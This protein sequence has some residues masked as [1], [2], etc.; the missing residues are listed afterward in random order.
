MKRLLPVLL[1]V[2][3]VGL[4]AEALAQ[5]AAPT[6]DVAPGSTV[7]LRSRA[8]WEGIGREFGD[9]P[10]SPEKAK[11]IAN[12][13]ANQLLADG[14]PP[15]FSL[16]RR[17]VSAFRSGR[18]STA[19][20]GDLGEILTSAFKGAGFRA[21][22]VDILVA[23]SGGGHLPDRRLNPLDVNTNH[24]AVVVVMEGV[25]YAFDL[26]MHAGN[27]G[28]SG[29]ELSPY[30]GM[31]VEAW[32][33]LMDDM[34][35]GRFESDACSTSGPG[36]QVVVLEAMVDRARLITFLVTDGSRPVPNATVTFDSV[37]RPGRRKFPPVVTDAA[38][39]AGSRELSHK[40][41]TTDM[42]RV[43]VKAPG[44]KDFAQNLAINPIRQWTY[45][46]VLTREEPKPK[47]PPP[48]PLPPP[49]PPGKEPQ[50]YQPFI[51]SQSQMLGPL[52]TLFSAGLPS[53]FDGTAGGDA[54]PRKPAPG[55]TLLGFKYFGHKEHPGLDAYLPKRILGEGDIR[56][57]AWPVDQRFP[58]ITT[59]KWVVYQWLD[60]SAQFVA[61]NEPF[62]TPDGDW[63]KALRARKQDIDAGKVF[64]L[65]PMLIH[66]AV[67]TGARVYW[68]P[69]GK[70]EP[71][72]LSVGV[73]QDPAKGELVTFDHSGFGIPAF[74]PN[75][76]ALFVSD[77][78]ALTLPGVRRVVFLDL[79]TLVGAIKQ[80]QAKAP[81]AA[82]VAAETFFQACSPYN[83]PGGPLGPTQAVLGLFPPSVLPL[84]LAGSEIP[85]ACGSVAK[86]E[87]QRF[88]RGDTGAEFSYEARHFSLGLADKLADDAIQRAHQFFE[89]QVGSAGPARILY[90]L[91]LTGADE[92]ALIDVSAGV[93]G[94]HGHVLTLVT[95]A[96]N[97][98]VVIRTAGTVRGPTEGPGD[99]G[100]VDEVVVAG[101]RLATAD[102]ANA[103]LAKLGVGKATSSGDRGTRWT[104]VFT[105]IQVE[106]NAADL[107]AGATKTV[108]EEVPLNAENRYE[109]RADQ[110]LFIKATVQLRQDGGAKA[111][112]TITVS[113]DQAASLLTT[114]TAG[115][116]TFEFRQAPI[117]APEA[118]GR[119]KE[120]EVTFRHARGVQVQNLV[121]KFRFLPGGERDEDE[122]DRDLP[123]GVEKVEI[124]PP[125]CTLVTGESKTW[126]AEHPIERF[127]TAHRECEGPELECVW[128]ILQGGQVLLRCPTMTRD[129]V[130]HSFDAP[131]AYEVR[132]SLRPRSTG[133]VMAVG[134]SAVV[135]KAAPPKPRA[136][137]KYGVVEET[138]SEGFPSDFEPVR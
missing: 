54:N 30:N 17:M 100:G 45:P 88:T 132:L 101:L 66:L 41:I 79:P 5:G 109:I 70:K 77:K 36:P 113:G 114:D 98:V 120:R 6:P 26:W 137:S 106:R 55:E 33:A 16:G 111:G 107:R 81:E 29:F 51:R 135:V 60:L 95:R 92:T 103:L 48:P 42:Y 37:T 52:R 53:Y 14:V 99:G 32:C 75:D 87:A 44:F 105:R 1:L 72:H 46:I 78:G 38:G 97:V 130:H 28:F 84:R 12:R 76:P 125:A 3:L 7:R 50:P 69:E 19:A 118:G 91:P 23:H 127:Q 15:N 10:E 82:K 58:R 128:E 104:L 117:P 59:M 122:G 124:D 83:R 74:R 13:V 8:E 31:P 119:P 93:Q 35:Y 73:V 65:W 57:Q 43:A 133:K 115:E 126:D 22:Q 4:A 94:Y 39:R 27:T 71:E 68:T 102:L 80:G 2:F 49:P 62:Q 47:E 116:A 138:A 64:A 11:K 9:E 34:A 90:S 18:L 131:G 121:G 63:D 136:A 85:A 96:S 24:A 21:D 67:K 86:A 108:V 25:S 56:A 40:D 112:E 110:D 20:C 89:E 134:R 61:L 129:Y 123:E